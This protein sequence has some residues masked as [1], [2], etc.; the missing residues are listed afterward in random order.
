MSKTLFVASLFFALAIALFVHIIMSHGLTEITEALN[1]LAV[2]N[3]Q[4]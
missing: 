3:Q 1:A 2:A 4:S